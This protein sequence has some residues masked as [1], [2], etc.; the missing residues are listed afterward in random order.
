MI[1]DKTNNTQAGRHKE[2]AVSRAVRTVWARLQVFGLLKHHSFKSKT[3][4]WRE[5]LIQLLLGN[6][7]AVWLG[8]GL[9][10]LGFSAE[11][12]FVRIWRALRA[13]ALLIAHGCAQLGHELVTTA[14]PGAA[15]MLREIFEP[16]Y[17]MLRGAWHLLGH[18]RR[19]R[20][21]DGFGAAVHA[22]GEFI[23]SGVRRN[24]RLLPQLL[25]YVLPLLALGVMVGVY[26]YAVTRPYT[27][28]VQVNGQTVGYVE[29]EE[30]FNSAREDVQER[31]NYAGTSK[32]EWSVEPTYTLAVSSEVMDENEMANALIQTSGDEISEGTALYLDGELTAVCAD[33]E[34][35]Q[36]YLDSLTE[37]YIDEND[38]NTTVSFSR[39]V[40]FEKGIYFNDSFNSFEDIKAML[41][42][43]R[44]E[45]RVYTVKAGDSIS[46]IA[47]ANGLTMRELCALNTDFSENGLAQ[48]S[49]ILPGDELTV[50]KE[51]AMLEV[52]IQKIETK[53]EKIPFTTETTKSDEYTEGT[54]KTT[55]EGE[56][57]LRSVTMQNLY[58]TN[59]TLLEQII[60]NTEVIKEPVTEKVTVGT[61]KVTVQTA[62][63]TGSGQFIWPVPG[64]KYCSRWFGGSHKGVDICASAGVPIY[65]T[66]SGTVS[67]AGYNKAGAGTGYGYSVII[68]HSGG[69]SSVYAHCSSLV[70]RAGQSVRQGQLIGYVGS[71]GRSTGNHCHF[72]IRLNGTKLSVQKF[73]PSYR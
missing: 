11:Y 20:R 12:L 45:K 58:D 54:T 68:S 23:A 67:K 56:N 9:Y 35:L 30:V 38:P 17:V 21:E 52:R 7:L 22:S 70:V 36:S 24:A 19:A 28:A 32:T 10:A 15:R 48:D 27:L 40:T 26:R 71:T 3:H 43:V 59:G 47:S 65:A 2:N 13:G 66:A 33:G 73:F 29:N 37:P 62:Y 44:Q 50:T 41:A 61:K 8:A 57:G 42:G 53:E 1:E 64:Y 31:I 6:P 55:Q 14:F 69:Y 49:T 5:N 16:I 72:E 34:A 18:V 63:I 4:H 46:G 25:M 51:E 39:E 60:L